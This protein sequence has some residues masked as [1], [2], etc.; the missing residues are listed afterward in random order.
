MSK[1]FN[2][3]RFIKHV[4]TTGLIIFFGS[5]LFNYQKEFYIVRDISILQFTI[6]SLLI[7]IGIALN[8]SKLNLIASSFGVFLRTREWLALSSLTTVLNSFF[9]KAGAVAISGYLKKKHDF[10]YLFFAGTFF[11]DQLIMLFASS[12]IGSFISLYLGFFNQQKLLPIL[13]GFMLVATLLLLLM[14]G[15]IRVPEKNNSIFDILRNG[16][17]S[18]NTL[19][20]DK[21]LLHLLCLHNTLL[22]MTIGLRF[23]ATS[24]ILN[25]E[26]PL[27][28]CFLFASTMILVRVLPVTHSDI[29]VREL[30]IGF[31]ANI[32]GDSLKT[33]ILATAV[34]RIFELF[35]TGLCTGIF[36]N[37]LVTA[38]N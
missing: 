20:L 16:I 13:A 12:L 25:L 30:C 2:T 3:F 34:D 23:Y 27:S 22:V 21:K 17:E 1:T 10:P 6:I 19:F 28:H 31:L 4:L 14:R 35:W 8:G 15:D 29:G 11:G 36:R 32:I 26:I 18:F 7:L 9:F 33:G 5:L 24:S 37:A 38:K